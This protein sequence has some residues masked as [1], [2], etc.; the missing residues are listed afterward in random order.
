MTTIS[1]ELRCNE[2]APN[3]ESFTIRCQLDTVPDNRRL[4]DIFQ[5]RRDNRRRTMLD[6]TVIVSVA[7]GDKAP[8]LRAVVRR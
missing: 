8:R 2:A 4:L 6:Q 3:Q 7:S 5:E 1:L